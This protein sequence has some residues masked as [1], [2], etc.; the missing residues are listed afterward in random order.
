MRVQ[1][2]GEIVLEPR[3]F[4]PKRLPTRA[5]AD[6]HHPVLRHNDLLRAHGLTS[7]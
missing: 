5:G 1:L 4:Q 6:F 2:D 3:E 7:A